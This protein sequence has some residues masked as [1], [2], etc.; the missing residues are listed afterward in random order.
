MTTLNKQ[1]VSG[2]LMNTAICATAFMQKVQ[3]KI[4]FRENPARPVTK[5]VVTNDTFKREA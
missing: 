3:S 2:V 5:R 1:I 4:R